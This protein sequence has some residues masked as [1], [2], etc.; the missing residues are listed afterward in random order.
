M[1]E[2]RFTESAQNAINL[3]AES[4][5][6]LGHNYVGTEHM[7][8]GLIKE[9]DGVAAKILESND[10]NEEN[11][12]EAIREMLGTGESVKEM[13]NSFTPRTKYVVQRSA[14]EARRLGH[15]YVGTEHLLIALLRE[16]SSIAAKILISLGAN[17]Q[18]LY[19]DVLNML[20]DDDGEAI[21]NGSQYG[22]YGQYGTGDNSEKQSGRSQKSDCPTLMKFGR[23]LTQMAREGKLD[24]IIGRDKAIE[25]VIQILSRRSKNN[26]CLIGEPGVGKT[27]VAEGLAQKIANGEVPEILKDKRVITLEMSS[28]L[29]GAKYRGEFE[30]RLKKAMDEIRKSGKIILFIDELHTIIGAGAAEGAIDAANI[31]KPALSRGEIQIVGAT[32]LGEYRKY[33]EKD[34]ALER[35]FQPITLDE[36]TPEETLE[37]LK[38]IRDKYEAHHRVKISDK[39]LEA[40][41][42]LSI[43]YISD[44][45]LPDKAIDLIDEAASRLKLKNM[46]APPDVRE[47]EEKIEAVKAEKE[48]AITTQEYERAAKLRDDEKSLREKLHETKENWSKDNVNSDSEVTENEIAEIISLWTGIP[49]KTLEESESERLLRLEEILHSRVVG[50]DEAVKAVA[51]AIRRGRVGLKDPKRPI[52]SFIFLGPT[53]VGKTELS[54]ALAEAMFGDEDSIIR[55]DMSEYMEKH[56]VSK[57]VGS[58]PGYVGFDEGG[59]LTDK[60]RTKPYSVILFDEIEKAHPDV[61]NILLQILEDG[62]LTDSQGRRV[63][64]RNT[65]II[66][67]SN[68]GARLITGGGT[69][70]LGFSAMDDDA[71]SERDYAQIKED[72]LGELK[73]AFKPEFLNRVDEI[74]VFHKLTKSNIKEIA[75]KMLESLGNRLRDNGITA[76]FTESAVEKISENGFDDNYGARPLR[77]AIQSDIEDMVAE[78][79]L[80]GKIKPG[81]AV[82]IDYKDDKFDCGKKV[83]V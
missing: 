32:T 8:L 7:L 50:Q 78:S 39:A 30:E 23:D 15:N 41:V 57:M 3:A 68:L 83:E 82:T 31:L 10:I 54:K 40:A 26:P 56:S 6:E 76:E 22:G 37:I 77:R 49:V 28:M 72:V 61:F 75:V 67:T 1:F 44:R 59:Q 51:K 53:G 80:E 29:A 60:V 74:I 71:E 58:P 17:P 42:N 46:T 62:I 35:R 66:M 63:D 2:N 38:G 9:G 16:T 64:F 69:K 43:R 14:V 48:A 25:R 70:Q 55:V 27:A 24:P 52:G 47:I 34:A 73:Q 5:M 12:T 18:K 33:I 36:P 21:G 20:S 11:V 79:M 19:S 81:D 4:A 45:F 65:I 13:P